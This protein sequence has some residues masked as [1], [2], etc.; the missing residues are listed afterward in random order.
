MLGAFQKMVLGI[1]VVILIIA[2]LI[3]ASM[4]MYGNKKNWP[5]STSVCPDWWVE[6][7]SGVCVNAKDLGI[8]PKQE[9]T[10]HQVMNFKIP[11]F[12]GSEGDCNKYNW[13]TKCKVTWDG[14]TYGV[15]NPCDVSDDESD[16]ADA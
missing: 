3:V 5:P 9:G 4:L 11:Q 14:V 12:T 8:C 1:A 2:L 10:E 7:G 15:D 6:D 13:A 16:D